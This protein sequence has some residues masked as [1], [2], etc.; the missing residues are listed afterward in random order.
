[1]ADC[2]TLVRVSQDAGR[3]HTDNQ[4]PDL[5]KLI[6]HRGD[7]EVIRYVINDSAS[8]P[9]AEYR[10]IMAQIE[11]DAHRGD[12]KYL[13]VWAADRVSREGIEALLRFVRKLSESKCSLISV[14][15][16]WLN[17][18]DAT[19]ELMIAISAWVAQQ[20]SKRR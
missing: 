16:P 1:M 20:E 12:W 17:G 18:S 9:G 6:T 14:Q 4:V 13:Y 10:R 2:A 11:A 19:V 8:N 5:E 7:N 3:Q 15:E